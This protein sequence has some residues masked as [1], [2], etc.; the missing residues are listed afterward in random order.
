VELPLDVS[1][2]DEMDQRDYW[3][4]AQVFK[5]AMQ[6][7]FSSNKFN[8]F[9]AIGLVEALIF[10]RNTIGHDP[11]FESFRNMLADLEKENLHIDTLSY[12]LDD[13]I[14]TRRI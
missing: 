5:R 8:P 10:L 6:P 2:G 13:Q 3:S 1:E 4:V 7:R 11:M 9:H 12:E 14:K